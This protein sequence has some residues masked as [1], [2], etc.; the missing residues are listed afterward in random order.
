MSADALREH[1][2]VVPPRDQQDERREG[3][4]VRVGRGEPRHQRVR[5]HVMDRD[6]REAVAGGEG[7]RVLDPDLIHT[8][9]GGRWR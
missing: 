9:G 2:H 3:G 8:E 6:H 1:E 4:R 7:E 5:L